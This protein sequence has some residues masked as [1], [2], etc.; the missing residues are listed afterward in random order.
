MKAGFFFT[1]VSNPGMANTWIGERLA[2]LALLCTRLCRRLAD[3]RGWLAVPGKHLIDGELP[4]P[5]NGERGQPEGA[6]PVCCKANS[7]LL[8]DRRLWCAPAQIA[9]R[10]TLHAD[11]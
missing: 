1:D 2:G 4:R 5:N 10:P 6:I 8:F 9:S 3:A 7:A 11:D